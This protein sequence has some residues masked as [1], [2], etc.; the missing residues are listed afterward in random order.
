VGS[1]REGGRIGEGKG[2]SGGREGRRP[3][4]MGREGREERRGEGKGKPCI[5]T[6]FQPQITM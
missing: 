1:G 5:F 3:I 4:S 2:R 6:A